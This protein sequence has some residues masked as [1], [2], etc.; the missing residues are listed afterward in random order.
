SQPKS[1]RLD[2]VSQIRHIHAPTEVDH[3]Q[4]RRVIDIYVAPSREDLGKIVRGIEKIIAQTQKPEGAQIDLRGSVQGMRASFKSFG[5]GLL[6]SVVL[7]YLILVAQFKSFIDPL[8]ILLA[9][10]TGFTGVLLTLVL[11]GTTLNIMSL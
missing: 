3:Y 9:V 7:V 4:L 2:A 10:P 6:L 5:L 8:L 11:C 1:T